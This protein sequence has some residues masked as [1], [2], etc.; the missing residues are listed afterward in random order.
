MARRVLNTLFDALP[1][2]LKVGHSRPHYYSAPSLCF[3][4]PLAVGS[5][6]SEVP[7][8]YCPLSVTGSQPSADRKGAYKTLTYRKY[9]ETIDLLL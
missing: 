1:L 2:S 5:N 6:A 4:L 9:S 7:S 3:H 8:I